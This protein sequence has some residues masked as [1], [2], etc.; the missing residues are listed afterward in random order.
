MRDVLETLKKAKE[1][2]EHVNDPYIRQLL[3]I[4]DLL[5][6][7]DEVA[8]NPE[9]RIKTPS[10]DLV[11]ALAENESIQASVCLD[12]ENSGLKDLFL[13]EIPKDELL[14][15]YKESEGLEEGDIRLLMW[16][17]VHTEDY[18]YKNVIK[19][20]EIRELEQEMSQEEREDV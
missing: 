7:I 5:S 13:A 2:I 19:A 10:G 11:V 18:T 9:M 4:D 15:I 3:N 1:V 20:E 8:K 14:E 12:N 6:E 16:E 17:D